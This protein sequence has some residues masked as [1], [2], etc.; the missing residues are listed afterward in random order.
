[1]ALASLQLAFKLSTAVVIMTGTSEKSR[2]GAIGIEQTSA[3]K[4]LQH[5]DILEAQSCGVG[6]EM[7]VVPFD[8]QQARA[9]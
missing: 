2:V 5:F 6:Y 9:C 8:H 3:M 1:M 4:S 7:T